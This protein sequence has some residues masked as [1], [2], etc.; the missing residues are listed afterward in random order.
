[1]RVSDEEFAREVEA[2]VHRLQALGDG[3]AVEGL[4]A[5][6]ADVLVAR[7]TIRVLWSQLHGAAPAEGP[8][9]LKAVPPDEAAG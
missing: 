5:A 3:L 9:T 2:L 8:P 6:S 7:Q 1:M 4:L